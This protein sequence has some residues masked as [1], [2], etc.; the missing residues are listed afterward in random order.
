MAIILPESDLDAKPAHWFEISLA[1]WS[2]HRRLREEQT[3]VLL[4]EQFAAEARRLEIGAIEYCSIFFPD[5]PDHSRTLADLEHRA[6]D[7]DVRSLLIMV[8]RQGD[9]GNPDKRLRAE[10]VDN[11]R[12]WLEVAA[13][14]GCHAIRVNAKSV[15]SDEEQARLV[16]DGLASVCVHGAEEG[17]SVLV[18]NHGGLSSRPDWLMGVIESVGM[19]NC[20]TLPDFG[21]F[22]DEDV[23]RYE[24][25]RAMMPAAKA[26]SAKS[27]H[28]TAKG[29]E[30]DIDYEQMLT[31]VKNAGYS[32]Y[33]G[34]E[35]EGP[36]MP[37]IEG[38]QRTRDLLIQLRDRLK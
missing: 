5:R 33:V 16:A 29:A 32:G 17:L 20:G 7:H 9:L 21:N 13:R 31:I 15:G 25:V 34:I 28:F 6:A 2:F 26:V 24:A 3:P 30:R 19:D 1:E 14:L 12:R 35:F 11:H 27:N 36:D 4:H 37:E 23:D 10:A 38:V 22:W 18:E 8:D